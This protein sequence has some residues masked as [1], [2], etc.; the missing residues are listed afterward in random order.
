MTL[1][2]ELVSGARLPGVWTCGAAFKDGA[3]AVVGAAARW[4]P[5]VSAEQRRPAA[6][7][8]ELHDT[9]HTWA[10]THI[11]V[12]RW[13]IERSGLRLMPC[14]DTPRRGDVHN[15]DR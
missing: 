1:L 15:S 7:L 5:V 9:T 14:A 2:I 3:V 10:L 6:R 12:M 11:H 13:D 8:P 4:F